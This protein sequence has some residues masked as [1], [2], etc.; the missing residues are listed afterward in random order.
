MDWLTGV[1]VWFVVWMAIPIGI[2]MYRMSKLTLP[3]KGWVLTRRVWY[4]M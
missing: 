4:S 3:T 2:G 1:G